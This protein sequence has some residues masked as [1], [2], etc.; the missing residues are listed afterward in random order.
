MILVSLCDAMKQGSPETMRALV[1]ATTPPVACVALYIAVSFD[2]A[3]IVEPLI[4]KIQDDTIIVAVTIDAIH[5]RRES[6]V[7]A[8]IHAR[9]SVFMSPGSAFVM[10]GFRLAVVFALERVAALLVPFA[11]SR[12]EHI[13]EASDVMDALAEFAVEFGSPE[14]VAMLRR[15]GALDPHCD[16]V[17]RALT[18]SEAAARCAGDH[19]MG[20]VCNNASVDRHVRVWVNLFAPSASN[21]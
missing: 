4:Q 8:L 13:A 19:V 5:Q 16:K 1:S 10:D 15:T 3:D 20:H 17:R 18:R 12:A 2:R 9:P 21:D 6:V 11:V 14:M 7:I